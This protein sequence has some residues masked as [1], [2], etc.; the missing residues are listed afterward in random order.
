[1][2]AGTFR[3]ISRP[4]QSGYFRQLDIIRYDRG[5]G[6]G[7]P[8]EASRTGAALSDVGLPGSPHAVPHRGWNTTVFNGIGASAR[9]CHGPWIDGP[10]TSFLLLLEKTERRRIA[11]GLPGN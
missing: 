2:P 7:T 4:I 9:V 6:P 8:Q 5:R 11:W 1:M 3:E 10:R